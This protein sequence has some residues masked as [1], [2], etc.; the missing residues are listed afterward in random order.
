MQVSAD[1]DRIVQVL[2]NLLSNAAKFSPRGADVDVTVQVQPDR[3][4]VGVAD[5][6]AGVPEAFRG[7]IFERFA[8]ADASDRRLKGGSGL[9]LNICRSIL[10]A[11]GG[12][13]D[14]SSE[15]DV[16]TEFFFDLPRAGEAA[17]S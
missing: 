13:I 11:H 14:F 1:R 9:G 10:T 3:V 17:A 6:G 16:R 4:R 5:R 7:R 12:S 2:V 15:P 8:Q